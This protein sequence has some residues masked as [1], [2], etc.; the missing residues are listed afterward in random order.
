[1]PA[2]VA[3]L[4]LPLLILLSQPAV[5]G[6]EV[7]KNISG[8]EVITAEGLLNKVYEY[9]GLVIVDT[10]HK[11][12]RVQ[13]YIEGSVNLSDTDTDCS[14]LAEIISSYE[15]PA[16]FYCNGIK[17][18]RSAN[19]IHKAIACGYEKIYWLRGGFNEWKAKGFPYSS[20]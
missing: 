9:P 6:H 4:L 5:S 19:A 16:M 11:G 1:M 18:E 20:K 17:C 14:R 13:G 8:A 3:K 12:D 2:I 15:T 7:V 10:R